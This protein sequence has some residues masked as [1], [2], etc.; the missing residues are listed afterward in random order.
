M[1]E[2]QGNRLL[3]EPI[4]PAHASPVL[5]G[6]PTPER[7]GSAVEEGIPLGEYLAALRRYAWLVVAAVVLSMGFAWYKLQRQVP[8]YAAASTVR[9]VN[10][11]EEM[12][13]DIAPGQVQDAQGWYTDP[14]LSQIQLLRSRAVAAEVVDS[15][16]LRLRPTRPGFP[17]S[18]I[19]TIR[20]SPGAPS[21]DTVSFAFRAGG[22]EARMRGRTAAAPYG[23]PLDLGAV[24]VT[25]AGRPVGVPTATFQ[26]V[27]HQE[28]V[29]GALAAMNVVQRELTNVIDIQ[30]TADDPVLAKQGANEFAAAF[31]NV[32]MRSAQ[33]MSRRRREFVEEQLRQTDGLLLVA[34]RQLSDFRR[35]VRA[36]SPREKFRVTEEGLAGFRLQRQD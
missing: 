4:P 35:G 25:F 34:Q 24:A 1:P 27:D 13:G 31:R 6:T 17:R 16:G 22:V 8:H 28:A 15:L 12:A 21:G 5:R 9:L 20:V 29:L 18:A 19:E 26:V 10:A 7:Y 11:R 14:I 30:F 3:P 33:T 2:F 32:S 36:F 23:K